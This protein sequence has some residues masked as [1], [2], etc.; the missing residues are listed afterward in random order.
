M[1][2]NRFAHDF[3]SYFDTVVVR[4]RNVKKIAALQNEISFLQTQII[5]YG[6]LSLTESWAIF[7]LPSSD[8]QIFQQECDSCFKIGLLPSSSSVD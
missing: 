5:N 1:Q 3:T 4:L 6:R 2:V 7:D 8:G